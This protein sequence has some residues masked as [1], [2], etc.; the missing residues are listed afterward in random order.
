MLSQSN[1]GGKTFPARKRKITNTATYNGERFHLHQV[2]ASVPLDNQ[3][4]DEWIVVGLER[5]LE[6]ATPDFERE[7][8]YPPGEIPDSI[9]P[10]YAETGE[11]I[12]GY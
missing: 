7:L 10:Q 9:E 4:Q 11:P 8:E 1:S 12:F 6:L 5:G 2:V 3:N